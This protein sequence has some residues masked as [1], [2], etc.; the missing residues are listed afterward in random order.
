TFSGFSRNASGVARS[1][2]RKPSQNPPAP[3]KV[4]MPLSALTPAPVRAAMG[5]PLSTASRSRAPAASMTAVYS[6][7]AIRNTPF[8]NPC[9]ARPGAPRSPGPGRGPRR[10]HG[11]HGHGRQPPA[12]ALFLLCLGLVVVHVHDEHRARQVGRHGL[13]DAAQKQ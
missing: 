11:A 3:R 8:A 5:S 7:R 2:A 9:G 12:S 4:G 13:G 1:S 6:S 10:M